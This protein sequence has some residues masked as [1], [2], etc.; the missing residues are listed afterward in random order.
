MHAILPSQCVGRVTNRTPTPN[1][2]NA[3]STAAFHID[4][5]P[6]R[7]FF[8]YLKTTHGTGSNASEMNPN[9]LV[10]QLIPKFVYTTPE[11]APSFHP[12]MLMLARTICL[13]DPRILRRPSG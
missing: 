6:A 4:Y 11:L 12:F 3:L 1:S 9:K 7:I 5:A 2:R 10:T 8:P 13:A